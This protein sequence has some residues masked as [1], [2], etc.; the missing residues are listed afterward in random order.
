MHHYVYRIDRPSNGEWYIGIRSSK[1]WPTEDPYMG[2]G[3]RIK[4]IPRDELRK[5]VLVVVQTREEAARLEG[6]LV[7]PDQLDDPKCLNLYQGGSR[8]PLGVS[9]PHSPEAKAK[10]SKALQGNSYRKGKKL[11]TAHREALGFKGRKHSEETKRKIAE[12]MRGN[13]NRENSL[14]KD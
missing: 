2:S 4:R 9:I 14:K 3:T 1:R 10:I 6:L 8:G 5:T 11:S 13:R 7:G 12:S